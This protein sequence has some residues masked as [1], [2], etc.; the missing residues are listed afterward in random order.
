MEKN[1]DQNSVNELAWTWGRA[2]GIE[3]SEPL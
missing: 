1:V 2:F 3:K